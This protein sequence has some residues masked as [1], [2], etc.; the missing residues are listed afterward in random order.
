MQQA[1]GLGCQGMLGI[2]WRHRIIDP[3]ATYFARASWDKRLTSAANYR[4]Y[5]GALAQ[6]DRIGQLASIL[7]NADRQLG[8]ASTFLG[9]YNKDG[10]ADTTI[11]ADL[12]SAGNRPRVAMLE[13]QR[14]TV[15]LFSELMSRIDSPVERDRVGY[16]AGFVE[17]MVPYCDALAK[18]YE[19]Q[20]VL[21]RAVALRDQRK[22][23]EARALVMEKAVPLWIA[24]A[25]M[26]RET[27][28]IYQGIVATRNDQGQ[29]ASMQ[30]KFV[31]VTLERLRLSIKEFLGELPTSMEGAYVDA[32]SCEG[33]NAPRLFIPTRPS[34]LRSGESVRVFLVLPGQ[35][36]TTDVRL[37]SRRS[38]EKNWTSVAAQHQ[39]RSVYSACLGPFG[40]SDATIEY[41]AATSGG[42]V[43]LSA[44][45]EAPS[46]HYTLNIFN[47]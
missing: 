37:Y 1:R 3:T 41:Y 17:M 25:P 28:L 6:G 20:A 34:L 18:A 26:V 19:I 24:M 10:F 39:G 44:P 29:L 23:E 5:C 2:H 14:V 4:F 8:I 38:R 40:R 45:I 32:T 27:M 43:G 9:T 11:L 33:A 35:A 16:F 22:N 46:N 36:G 13:K 12:T 30:N 42:A 21:K 15:K 7:E 31:R 47:L